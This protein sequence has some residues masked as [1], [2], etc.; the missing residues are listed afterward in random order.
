MSSWVQIANLALRRLGA[1]RISALGEDSEEGRAVNDTYQTVRD[2]VLRL[3]PWNCATE[4]KVVTADTAA[5]AFGFLHQYT[6]PTDPYC[7]RVMKVNDIVVEKNTKFK[8]RRR[9]IHTDFGSP[10]NL[11]YI[12]RVTNPQEFDSVLVRCMAAHLAAAIAF[13]L[14]NSRKAEDNMEKWA[15]R[16]LKQ[17]QTPDAQ[18]ESPDDIT[19]DYLIGERGGADW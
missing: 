8:V 7:L 18:E 9:K 19:A 4:L 17:A 10:I 15:E 3:H 13:R 11:E 1:D 12:A 16:S 5:P 6:L 14:T 2:D